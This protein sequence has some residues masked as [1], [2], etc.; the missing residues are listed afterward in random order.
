M[1]RPSFGLRVAG[2]IFAV[3]ALA[4]L[5]RVAIRPEVFVAGRAMPL[6]PSVVAFVVLGLLSFWMLKLSRAHAH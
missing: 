3:M 1:D 6:W 2:I 5:G 4:Q